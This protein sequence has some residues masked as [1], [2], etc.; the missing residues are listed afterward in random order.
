MK[1]Y[2]TRK[3]TSEFENNMHGFIRQHENKAIP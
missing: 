1:T 2:E 3:S